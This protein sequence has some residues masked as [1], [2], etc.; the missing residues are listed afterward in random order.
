MLF[1]VLNPTGSLTSE[2]IAESINTN[3]G[4]V[5]QLM[6][7]LRK[8]GLINSVKGHPKPALTKDISNITLLDIYKA[9]EGDASLLHLDAHTNSEC[10]V[11]IN[12]QLAL[13]KFFNQIQECAE[14]EMQCISLENILEQYYHRLSCFD[15][16]P[17]SF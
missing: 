8:Y 16:E 9:V 12:I 10:G 13:K 3:P 17:P 6:S 15:K 11:G 7:A 4:Y 14:H 1:I 2:K 5:R